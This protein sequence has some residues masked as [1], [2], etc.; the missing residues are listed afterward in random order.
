MRRAVSSTASSSCL[1]AGD[2]PL[3]QQQLEGARMRELG[4]AAEA[5]MVRVDVTQQRLRRAPRQGWVDRT[6]GRRGT[7]GASHA[8]EQLCHGIGDVLRALAIGACDRLQHP[9]KS[10]HAVAIHRREIGAPVERLPVWREEHRQRPAASADQELHRPHVHVVDIGALLA[11]DLD[12]DE[13]A[14]HQVRN[15]RVLEALPLHDMA[16]VTRR[17][18]DREKNGSVLGTRTRECLVA[19]RIPIHR[20]VGVLQQIRAALMRQAIG[21]RH[22]GV[23]AD[24]PFPPRQMSRQST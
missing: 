12:V 4:R 22:I 2:T 16:P 19:P 9:R 11:I 13:V 23:H 10:G 7:V 17:V 18:A 8:I 5:A 3:P 15:G 6:V 20:V 14:I 1:V 24:T 21:G